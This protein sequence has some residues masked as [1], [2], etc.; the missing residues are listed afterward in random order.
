MP[1]VHE[2]AAL[3]EVM[4]CQADRGVQL[5]RARFAVDLDYSIASARAVDE[6]LDRVVAADPEGRSDREALATMVGSYVGE[7]LRRR[8]KGCSWTSDVSTGPSLPALSVN[9]GRTY[10]VERVR[11][12]L[13]EPRSHSIAAYV[14]FLERAW[15]SDSIAPPV[16]DAVGPLSL[17][18]PDLHSD[19]ESRIVVFDDDLPALAL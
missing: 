10:P 16:V 17:A 7:V 11:Q 6:L 1:N 14:D 12:C 19:L 5:V 8:T 9:G 15:R 2:D 4:H 18:P 13:R 3:N